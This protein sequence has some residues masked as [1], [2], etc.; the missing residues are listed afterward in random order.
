MAVWILAAALGATTLVTGGFVFLWRRSRL[1]VASLDTLVADARRAIRAAVDEETTRHTEAI[2][3]VLARER[4]ESTTAL[5]ETERR[6]TAERLASVEE[7]ERRAGD[8]LAGSLA[9]TEHKLEER[10]RGFTDDLDRAQQHLETRLQRVEQDR[11]R[12]I[13]RVQ[14][15]IEADAATL[16]TSAEAQRQSVLHLRGEVEQ[17]AQQAVADALREIES[18]SAERR[19]AIEDIA[20]RQ[21]E[22]EQT[23]AA[24]IEAAEAGVRE[25][26]AAL[27]QELERR[28]TVHLDKVMEREVERAAQVGMLQVEERFREVREDAVGRLERELDRAV[29]A[30]AR[31]GLSHRLSNE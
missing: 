16:G 30:L 5:A 9:D 18:H 14:V 13:E 24:S 19:R 26:L 23:I 20:G 25:R 31:A 4:S 17:A 27:L 29:E 3:V 6:L 8:R 7:R 10:L 15:R 11:E 22:R 28:Q 21:R 2:R 12:A 1:K